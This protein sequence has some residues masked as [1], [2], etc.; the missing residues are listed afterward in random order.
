DRTHRIGQDKKVFAYKLVSAET[1]DEKVL[2]LQKDKR[3]LAEIL[4][5]GATSTIGSLTRKDLEALLS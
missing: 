1:I 2:A 5:S 3:E 4:Q